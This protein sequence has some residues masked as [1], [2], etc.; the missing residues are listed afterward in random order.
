MVAFDTTV[1]GLISGAI[2]YFISGIRKGWYEQDMT[3]TQTIMETILNVQAT[4]RK[5][6]YRRMQDQK[7]QQVRQPG[8]QAAPQQYMQAA[9]LQYAQSETQPYGQT[10]EA[11]SMNEAGGYRQK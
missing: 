1:A 10:Y 4:E 9:P 5:K 2:S 3:W 7:S 6:A 8:A 11:Q